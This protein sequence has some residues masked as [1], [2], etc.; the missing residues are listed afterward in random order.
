MGETDSFA[1]E[2]DRVLVAGATGGTGRE[3]LRVLEATDL[4]V[5]GLTRSLDSRGELLA[6]GADEAVVGDLLDAR[7]AARAVRGCDAVLCA[8]GTG[9]SLDPLLGKPLVDGEGVR[10][11]VNA[12]VAADCEA[13]VFESSIGVGDSASGM[14]A[15][16]RWAIAPILRSKNRAEAA[17]R[18]SGLRYT[19]VRPGGLTDGP[20]TGDV[21]VGEGGATVSGSVPRADVARLMVAALSTP[22]AANRTVEVV[23][24]SGLRGT[25]RGLVELDWAYPEDLEPVTIDIEDEGQNEAE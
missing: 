24:R 23:A 10:N 13:F 21:L 19:I 2:I 18:S 15:P 16:F 14:P 4:E 5:V 25:P 17:L 9:P 7:D 6:R 1:E 12:A 20:A 8:V 11:L 22:D 3:I